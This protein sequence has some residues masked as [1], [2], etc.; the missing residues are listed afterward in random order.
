MNEKKKD[1]IIRKVVT[2]HEKN[3]YLE[4]NKIIDKEI[5][6]F[7]LRYGKKGWKEHYAR[8]I[9]HLARASSRLSQLAKEKN[10]KTIKITNDE[11]DVSKGKE[12]G[13]QGKE[14]A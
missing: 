13:I 11:P 7:K 14:T 9:P 1:E 4:E 6:F 12:E 8:A 3:I 2:D 10:R 5:A